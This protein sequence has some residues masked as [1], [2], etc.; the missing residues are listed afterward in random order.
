M[1][2]ENK[3]ILIVED[4][5][6]NSILMSDFLQE[7]KCIPLTATDGESGLA[8]LE[9][10]QD[11]SAV[12]LDWIM[13]KMNGL[14]ML[15]RIKQT[16]KFSDI[17]II[18]Q[19]GKSDK[20]SIVEGIAAGA[21]YY[22]TKPYDLHVLSTILKRAI[23]EF[24]NHKIIIEQIREKDTAIGGF[25]TSGVIRFKTP[26]EALNISS[27]FSK[28]TQDKKTAIGLSELLINAVEHGNLGIGYDK[29]EEFL[30]D[31]ILEQEINRRL[32]EQ[33]NLDKYVS[34]SFEKSESNLKINIE[35]MGRGFDFNK[36]LKIDPERV[37]DLHGRGIAMA[38]MS[39]ING[40][41]FMG[42]G[43]KVKV[44]IRIG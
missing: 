10:N 30:M 44:D 38:N 6:M 24:E 11:V 4:D 42:T 31:D 16:K 18:M 7:E 23:K 1:I 32:R 39:F 35:D 20:E 14:E 22:L 19:T 9:A 28:F 13:P 41:Q 37:F 29:K 34:I 8:I 25:L 12:I 3:K 40:I 15:K 33:Q 43:N 27:W 5:P 26:E 21:Y 2:L 36:Y 17:P